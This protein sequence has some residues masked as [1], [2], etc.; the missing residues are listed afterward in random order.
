MCSKSFLASCSLLFCVAAAAAQTPGKPAAKPGKTSTLVAQR[1]RFVCDAYGL[2]DQQTQRLRAGL[3]KL[4]SLNDAYM[5][6][7]RRTLRRQTKAI[8]LVIP[9]QSQYDEAMRASIASKIQDEIYDIYAKAPLSLANVVSKTEAMLSQAGIE[10]GRRKIAAKYASLLKGKPLN[11]K[12]LDRLILKPVARS[13]AAAAPAFAQ[14]GANAR[15]R[16][17]PV[18]PHK[19]AS[20][21]TKVDRRANAG[22]TQAP[23]PP[24]VAPPPKRNT[25]SV[26]RAPPP[27]RPQAPLS[28]APPPTDWAGV[29]NTAA[30]QYG[31]SEKQ[32]L[33]A[34]AA[35]K[36]CLER[37]ES[38]LQ[39]NGESLDRAK[40]A[41]P[42]DQNTKKL[43]ELR[44]PLDKLFNEL[45][46]R[47]ESIATVE[48]VMAVKKKEQK[49][50]AKK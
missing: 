34:Q 43:L 30:A 31:F 18:P 20:A 33:V 14:P 49:A 9:Q 25:T 13:T 5:S 11:I 35:L 26:K 38:Y 28:P 10:R 3:E 48:Q 27:P 17:V 42:S 46:Q 39:K 8:S 37:A 41:A 47:I 4:Q 45:N 7:Y 1:M 29:L 50:S 23:T 32:N 36:S 16:A 2:N 21:P 6:R 22:Q 24:R 40:K 44:R 12:T 15:K 19:I